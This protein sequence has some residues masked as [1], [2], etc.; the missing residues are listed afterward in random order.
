MLLLFGAG[1][2][3][4]LIRAHGSPTNGFQSPAAIRESNGEVVCAAGKV[5][6]ITEEVKIGSQIPGVLRQVFVE[7]GQHLRKGGVI[8]ILENADFLARVTEAAAAIAQR[9]AALERIIN[10]ARDQER[11]EA[12]A[13]VDEAKAVV[14]DTQTELVRRK[15]LFST[16]DIAGSD[17][18]RAEREYKVAKARLA[19]AVQR[20]AF[21]DAPARSDDRAR[22]EADLALARAQHSEA[23]ALLEKTRVRAPFDGTV[24]KRFRKAGDTVSD[25][26]DTPIVS[27]GDDSRLRVRVEVDETD[28]GKLEVGDRAWFTAQ[29]FGN[30]KFWGRV[31]RIGRELGK[32]NIETDRPSDKSDTQILETLVDLEGRPPLPSG[33]RVDS[34]LIAK[35]KVF[36]ETVEGG[37]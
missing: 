29:A 7:E 31:A 20:Y 16:G 23:L 14:A 3:A 24:L 26:G 28:L 1:A 11:R 22:A 8:A 6:P 25:R 10:G 13:A 5:E 12:A 17:L 27:F 35:R 18:D 36:S 30:R 9:Q 15:A 34:F 19:Q 37:R 32:K 2:T 4:I 33:L 21:L